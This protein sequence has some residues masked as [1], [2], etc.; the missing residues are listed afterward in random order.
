MKWTQVV[1]ERA[2]VLAIYG[3]YWAQYLWSG[4]TYL[5]SRRMNRHEQNT[6]QSYRLSVEDLYNF[7]YISIAHVRAFKRLTLG[8]LLNISPATSVFWEILNA[9]VTFALILQRK[10]EFDGWPKWCQRQP[11]L[12]IESYRL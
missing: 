9:Q 1:V 10:G 12:S 4:S 11:S 8:F 2:A 6:V 3:Y 5:W 7:H